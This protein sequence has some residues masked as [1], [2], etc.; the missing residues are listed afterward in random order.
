M[1]LILGGRNKG[2]NFRALKGPILNHVKQ[3]IAIGEATNEIYESLGHLT[4]ITAAESMEAAVTDG[5]AAA[6][7]GD[8]V[9]L[10][11]ACASFD[12]YDSYAQRGE[13]F[14]QAFKAHSRSSRDI[15]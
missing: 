12:M 14:R 1:I 15:E 3:I 6:A 7:P 10:S 2:G 8:V 11:P 5:E 4:T 9:L 13:D